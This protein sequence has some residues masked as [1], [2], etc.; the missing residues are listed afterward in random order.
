MFRII[1][2]D[3]HAIVRAGLKQILNNYP[4]IS[5]IDDACDGQE[6]LNKIKKEDYDMI[7]LDISMPGRSGIDIL[8]QIKMEKPHIPVL[9]LSM[10]SE[11]QYALRTLKAGASGYLTKDLASE[12]LL[13][14]I[15]KV[16]E[17]GKYITQSQ[18]ELLADNFSES[19]D[20]KPHEFLSDREYQVF[21]RIVSGKSVTEIAN[22]MFLNIKTVSTYRRRI[23]NK[24]KLKN[25]SELT[26]YAFRYNLIE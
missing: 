4:G 22:E 19:G 25:N 16:R 17:G 26:H 2:A 1:I 8:K 9:V 14:A 5:K 3:D 13:E 6:L 18:A 10:H 21:Y 24:M 12:K 11:E 20:K 7:L 23:L 15:N